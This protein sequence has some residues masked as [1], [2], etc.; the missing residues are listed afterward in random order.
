M[1]WWKIG[2]TH[3]YTCDCVGSHDSDC[4]LLKRIKIKQGLIKKHQIKGHI[5]PEWIELEVDEKFRQLQKKEAAMIFSEKHYDVICD[6]INEIYNQID[7]ET[8]DNYNCN[9]M[10]MGSAKRI[11]RRIMQV[12]L[13]DNEHFDME[14]YFSKCTKFKA[15]GKGVGK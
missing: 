1:N 6:A 2:G 13:D 14:L 15:P 3:L 8:Y 10:P 9:P 7:F 5:V 11:I 12:F 4:L